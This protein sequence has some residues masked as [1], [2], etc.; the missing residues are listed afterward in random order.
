MTRES[1]KEGSR[2]IVDVVCSIASDD[3]THESPN[4]ESTRLKWRD[5]VRVLSESRR[6][7]LKGNKVTIR[8][9]AVETTRQFNGCE[10]LNSVEHRHDG[11]QQDPLGQ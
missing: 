7:R 11:D 6:R 3:S 2:F 4:G 8:S 10:V 5:C 9:A 1:R